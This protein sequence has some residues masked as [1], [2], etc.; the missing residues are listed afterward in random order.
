MSGLHR[1]FWLG[2]NGCRYMHA[3]VS[4]NSHKYMFFT[5]LSALIISF[6]TW[7]PYNNLEINHII[8]SISGVPQ[9]PG[10]ELEVSGG[11]VPEA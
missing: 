8:A 3:K 2:G 7:N 5:N 4:D 6:V 10:H 11:P 9:P 1:R